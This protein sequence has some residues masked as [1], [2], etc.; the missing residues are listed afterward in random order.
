MFCD[1]N[2]NHSVEYAIILFFLY[3]FG[4]IFPLFLIFLVNRDQSKEQTMRVQENMLIRFDD[5][6]VLTF[7]RF[8]SFQNH[9]NNETCQNLNEDEMLDEPEIIEE[10]SELLKPTL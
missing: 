3:I 5:N 7:T 4:E 9:N 1:I 10:K 8:D 6:S 2:K